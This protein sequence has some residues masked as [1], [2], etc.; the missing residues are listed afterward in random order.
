MNQAFL[1]NDL[2]LLV[3]KNHDSVRCVPIDCTA[4]EFYRNQEN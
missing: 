4:K 1:I 2:I 3:D